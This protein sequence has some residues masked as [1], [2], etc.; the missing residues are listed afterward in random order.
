MPD[1]TK[2]RSERAAASCRPNV[3]RVRHLRV[4]SR[5]ELREGDRI[6]DE[7]VR[8]SLIAC[9]TQGHLG[10]GKHSCLGA[11]RAR[12][13]ARVALESLVPELP[14]LKR[15]DRTLADSFLERGPRRLEL[16][17]AA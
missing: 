11:S 17:R 12:L 7:Y 6:I 15:R 2:G 10:F 5:S 4:L 16:E 14:C 9:D 13:E 8:R 1:G 3:L